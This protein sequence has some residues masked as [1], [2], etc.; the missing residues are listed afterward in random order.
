MQQ[1]SAKK[2][3]LKAVL[4]TNKDNKTIQ[5][6]LTLLETEELKVKNQGMEATK[7]EKFYKDK[8]VGIDREI[9]LK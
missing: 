6:E 8:I 7:K 3:A 1:L 4:A 9:T 2:E 5:K